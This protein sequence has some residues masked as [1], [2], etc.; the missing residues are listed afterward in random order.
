MNEDLLQYLWKVG[1][2]YQ[3]KL[4]LVSGEPIEV[5]KTGFH[6]TTAGPDFL[7]AKIK[8]GNTIWAGQVEIHV[9]TSH[10]VQHNHQND[11][12]YN[13]VILHVVWEHDK[14]I[15]TQNGVAPPVLQLKDFIPESVL[16]TYLNFVSGVNTLPCSG[17]IKEIEPHKLN[18]WLNS[19]AVDRLQQKAND[20]QKILAVSNNDWEEAFF[21]AFFIAMSF[22]SNKNQFTILANQINYK[23]LLKL[24]YSALS[25]EAYLFGIAGLLDTQFSEEYPKSL[26]KEWHFLK[27][28]Y[29]FKEL[30]RG[31]LKFGGVRPSNY[32]TIRLAQ[33]AAIIL[34]QGNIFNQTINYASVKELESIFQVEPNVYWRTHYSFEK[35]HDKPKEKIL[36]TDSLKLLIINLLAPVIFSYQKMQKTNFDIDKIFHIFEELKPEQ[37]KITALFKNEG[38]NVSNAVTAQSLIQL[39][40]NF[41]SEKKCVSCAI[42]TEIL[43]KQ[44]NFLNR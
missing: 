19:L 30:I 12:A 36:G 1:L 40:K 6:N 11:S 20:Y 10:W 23:A 15:Y 43:Q 8:I 38:L 24:R 2:P 31:K 32:P 13:N 42:G 7:E 35:P 21:K 28:K 14:E 37:N 22:N 18:I 17:K 33:I 4:F 16:N 29:G 27:Q 26:N 3:E 25:V 44:W 9:K 5:L 34:K 41:C 39:Y